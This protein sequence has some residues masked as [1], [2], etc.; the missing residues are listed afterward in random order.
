MNFIAESLILHEFDVY[1][2]EPHGCVVSSKHLIRLNG[3]NE[4]LNMEGHSKPQT[5]FNSVSFSLVE[6]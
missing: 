3:C 6:G 2:P 5:L 1:L 4:A